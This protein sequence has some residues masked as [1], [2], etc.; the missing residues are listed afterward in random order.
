MYTLLFLNPGNR[1]SHVMKHMDHIYIY[2]Q[3]GCVRSVQYVT[4]ATTQ[5]RTREAH[6]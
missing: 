2:I 5:G 1:Q 4:L 6:K 3:M